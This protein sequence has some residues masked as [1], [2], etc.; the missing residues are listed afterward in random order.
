[1][2]ISKQANIANN[3][4]AAHI[5]KWLGILVMLLGTAKLYHA[6]ISLS[7]PSVNGQVTNSTVTVDMSSKHADY[8][9]NV[10]YKYAVNGRQFKGRRLSFMQSEVRFRREGLD[11]I[12]PYPSGAHPKVYYDPSDHGFSV[13]KPGLTGNLGDYGVFIT[14]GIMFL[15]SVLILR[16][17]KPE[18]SN[19]NIH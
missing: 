7:W 8:M 16:I 2:P 15:V 10:Y 12:A 1:M 6:L 9:V 17:T 14:G 13:L 5:I 11:L 4:I 19:R 3:R 18:E